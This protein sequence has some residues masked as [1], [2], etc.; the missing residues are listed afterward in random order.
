MSGIGIEDFAKLQKH[1]SPVNKSPV[2]E[3]EEEVRLQWKERSL[4]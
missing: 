3:E 2:E 1:D 4:I